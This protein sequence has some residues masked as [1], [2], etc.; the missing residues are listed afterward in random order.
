[1]CEVMSS[2][3]RVVAWPCR[4]VIH[5]ARVGSSSSHHGW[6]AYRSQP[7]G[8][9]TEGSAAQPLYA[10]HGTRD[11]MRRCFLPLALLAYAGAG[12]GAG[13]RQPSGADPH[14]QQRRVSGQSDL[15]GRPAGRGVAKRLRE[16]VQH[17]PSHR[18][19]FHRRLA[20]RNVRRASAVPGAAQH[21]EVSG[22]CPARLSARHRR[23]R[24]PVVPLMHEAHMA[25]RAP[26][27]GVREIWTLEGDVAR[28]PGLWTRNPLAAS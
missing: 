17:D 11:S 7:H 26:E 20:D 3:Y 14:L 9:P 21:H 16:P 28:F 19:A 12:G 24:R 15:L 25:A 1:M 5:G 27:P 6:T 18:P 10:L 4:A 13:V 22:W 2:P 23:A 8:T